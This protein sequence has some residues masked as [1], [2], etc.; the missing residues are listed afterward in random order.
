MTKIYPPLIDSVLISAHVAMKKCD[1][2]TAY[3]LLRVADLAVTS[4]RDWALAGAWQRY[5]ALLH[6]AA[7][8]LSA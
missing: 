7:G 5:R 8:I 2:D 3:D 1:L 6:P 4:D